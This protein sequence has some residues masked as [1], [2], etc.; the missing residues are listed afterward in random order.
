MDFDK[1]IIELRKQYNS[2]EPLDVRIEK[3]KKILKD[4]WILIT[5]GLMIR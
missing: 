2:I 5:M 4:S 1:K 3:V